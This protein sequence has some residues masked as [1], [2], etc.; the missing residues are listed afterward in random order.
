MLTLE[1][2]S[3]QG[4]RLSVRD[5]LALIWRLVRS[6]FGRSSG[7]VGGAIDGDNELDFPTQIQATA[8]QLFLR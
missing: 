7:E 5:R 3:E 8:K 4:A 2:L 6:L 1:T